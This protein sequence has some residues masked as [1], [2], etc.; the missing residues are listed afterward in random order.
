MRKIVFF[1]FF[2][3]AFFD[4]TKSALAD[5]YLFN[6]FVDISH[7]YTNTYNGADQGTSN[8]PLTIDSNFSTYMGN[9]GGAQG[10]NSIV[11]S[12]HTFTRPV[13][14]NT[15]NYR[16]SAGGHCGGNYDKSA[17]YNMYVRYKAGGVWYY[18]PGSQFSGS[19]GD[20]AV[21]YDTGNV[22]YTFPIPVTN[23]TDIL[24]YAYGQ[25]HGEDRA[26][27]GS[28]AYIYE[29]QVTGLFYSD[30]GLRVY[31]GTGMIAI[32]TEPWGIFSQYS[33]L[34]IKKGSSFYA[35]ALVPTTDVS[36][37]KIRIQ[38]SSGVKALRKY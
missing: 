31:D 2:L 25:G 29:I 28:Y 6:N 16:I 11:I 14:I 12:Q 4:L 27:N 26:S 24:A 1:I 37:S 38:T 21:G 35:I 17:D 19:V 18:L 8:G 33:P 7:I 23:A 3:V 30:I 13:T 20:G 32:A 10:N 36:A 22:S 34:R 15:I 5:A 9:S